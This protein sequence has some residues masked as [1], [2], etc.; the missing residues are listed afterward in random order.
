VAEKPVLVAE[1]A[2]SPFSSSFPADFLPFPQ[3]IMSAPSPSA[4]GYLWVLS[5]PGSEATVE[6][7]QG[8]LR[9]FRS[10]SRPPLLAPG[11]SRL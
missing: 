1:A 4:P 2:S 8:K 10:F 7:F 5:E 11:K 6:E 9:T 3:K